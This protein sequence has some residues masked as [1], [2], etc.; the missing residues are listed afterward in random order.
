MGRAKLLLFPSVSVLY[1]GAITLPLGSRNLT[2]PFFFR[3]VAKSLYVWGRARAQDLL[4]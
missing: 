3:V 4:F 2:V 1:Q